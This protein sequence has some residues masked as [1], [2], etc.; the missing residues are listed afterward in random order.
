MRERPKDRG[1]LLH[2]KAAMEN[3][4]NFLSGKTAEDFLVD[5]ML[6]YAIVKNIEIIG[7]AAYMLTNDFK[8][9]HP[10]TNWKDIINMRHVLVHGYYLVDSRIIWVTIQ[11]DLPLLEE[12]IEEYLKEESFNQ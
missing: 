4:R 10:A 3:I 5:Q 11:N 8:E 1:R 7:E 2:I 9:T 12:Q 6:Y